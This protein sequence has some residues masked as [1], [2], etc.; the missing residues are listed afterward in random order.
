[1][2][3]RPEWAAIASRI[4]GL[5]QA[6]NVYFAAMAISRD[7]PYSCANKQ[8]LPE[9]AAIHSALRDFKS[10]HERSLPEGVIAA[11]D[12][13]G[14]GDTP[15]YF[16]KGWDAGAGGLKTVVP[17]L[18]ATRSEI[19]FHL[20]DFSASA[21]RLTERAFL[22]LKRSIVADKEIRQKWQDAFSKGEPDCEKLGAVH[23]LLHGIWA[24]KANEAGERTDLVL[25]DRIRDA[26]DV[27]HG[28]PGGCTRLYSCI[29]ARRE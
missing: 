14:S 19:A 23:L 3:L 1:M 8:L 17:V 7:D 26:S 20:A 28:P 10:R 29:C 6:T 15:K 25:G 2:T 18:V 4:D 22:H 11:I 21:K 24:F 12:R 9:G 13:I 27:E 16:T 5:V